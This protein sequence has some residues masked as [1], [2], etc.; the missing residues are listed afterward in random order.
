MLTRRSFAAGALVAVTLPALAAP[1][2]ADPVAILNAIYA[3]VAHGKG[4]DGGFV[5]AKPTRA[6]YL[7]KSLVALWAKAEVRTPKDEAGP[8][9]FDPVTNSQDPDVT[10]FDIVAEKQDSGSA[11]L[12]VT[13]TGARTSRENRADNVVRYDFTRDGGHWRIDDIRST[14]DGKPWS[15]RDLLTTSL[16]R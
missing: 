16:K 12:A 5:T 7:S 10:S 1:I 2:A 13:L 9:D 11:T 3:R 4:E 6:K 15:L 8:I 14:V